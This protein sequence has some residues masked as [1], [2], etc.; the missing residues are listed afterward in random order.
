MNDTN[1]TISAKHVL[2]LADSIVRAVK[3]A[4][5][6]EWQKR[7]AMFRSKWYRSWRYRWGRRGPLTDQQIR[8]KIT[9][10]SNGLTPEI[11]HWGKDAQAKRLR[12]LAS[13]ALSEHGD[14]T[15]FLSSTDLE[16]LNQ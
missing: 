11:W 5:E 12:D 8:D 6:A 7:I 2:H 13:L 9:L 15:V 1:A 14:Q 3:K 10:E 4:R 16:F